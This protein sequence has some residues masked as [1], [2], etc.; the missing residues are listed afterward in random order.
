M[1]ARP[2]GRAPA[3]PPRAL[4]GVA[5]PVLLAGNMCDARL[6]TREVRACLRH[7][8]DAD[9]SLDDTVDAMARRALAA[10]EGPLLPVG[11]SMGGIVALRMADLAPERIAGL[12]LLDTN[13]AA[14]LPERAAARPRQQADVRAGALERVV[15]EELKPN[16]LAAANRGD[17]ALL[18]LLRD[19][20]MGLGPDVFVRQ[21]EGLR[22]RPDQRR[23]LPTLDV[24][25]LL[26]CG[27]EDRLCPPDWHRDMA[28]TAPRATLHVV[29]D[30]GHMLPLERPD[31]L[32][33]HLDRWLKDLS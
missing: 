11:F 12:V 21:S 16:Y 6:W 23:V 13:A 18:D 15:V 2:R 1:V 28:A 7:A 3:A 27:A 4:T 19:M 31:A 32:A 10:V 8:V 26:A 33:R 29:E 14:D 20:A 9:L 22:T 25:V 5:T 30:A 17:A 24:P